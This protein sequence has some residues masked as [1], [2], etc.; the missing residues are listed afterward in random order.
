MAERSV[1]LVIAITYH[2]LKS[3]ISMVEDVRSGGKIAKDYMTAYLTE[4][5]GCQTLKCSVGYA[6]QKTTSFVKTILME[7]DLLSSGSNIDVIVQRYVDYTG[8]TEVTK[9]GEKITWEKTAT[10]TA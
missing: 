5:V 9:N 3:I 4:S 1:V 6:M 10:Q 8:N 2:F 7:I